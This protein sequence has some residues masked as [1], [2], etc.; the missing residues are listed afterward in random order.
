TTTVISK[1]SGS[2]ISDST[3]FTVAS[4]PHSSSSSPLK[5]KFI[6]LKDEE[7]EFNPLYIS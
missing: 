4:L 5:R 6:V 7:Q 3:I 2:T 1:S